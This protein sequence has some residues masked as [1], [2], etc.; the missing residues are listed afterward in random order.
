[1]NKA[2]CELLGWSREE[3]LGRPVW[4]LISSGQQA[5]SE[6]HVKRKLRGE[7]PLVPFVREYVRKDGQKLMFLIH[8]NLI[9]STGGKILGI[10]STLLDVT[11]QNRAESEL[12]A[13]LFPTTVSASPKGNAIGYSICSSAPAT[14]VRMA[15]EWDSP[16][17]RPS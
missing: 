11:E 16:F 10:R 9:L 6:A 8:E 13:S 15:P 5:A 1:V 4:Q 2:E 17:V 12:F 7:Q 3:L 14:S